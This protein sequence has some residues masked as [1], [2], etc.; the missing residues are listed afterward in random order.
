MIYG[1]SEG[2]LG[3]QALSM[4]PRVPISFKSQALIGRRPYPLRS[5]LAFSIRNQIKHCTLENVCYIGEYRRWEDT[6]VRIKEGIKRFGSFWSPLL[7]D[8]EMHGMLSI[9]D[10]GKI[11]LEANGPLMI[12]SNN[13]RRI[14]GRVEKHGDVTLDGCYETRT[15]HD[16]KGGISKKSFHVGTVLSGFAYEDGEIPLFNDLSFS[17]EGLDEWVGLNGMRVDLERN[18]RAATIV[19]QQP[20]DVLLALENGMQLLITFRS[21]FPWGFPKTSDQS[22][23]PRAPFKSEAT[24]CQKT[25]LKLISQDAR[26]LQ[27]FTTV[28]Q[29][30]TTLLCFATDQIVSVDKMWATSKTLRRDIGKGQT[31]KVP[32]GIYFRSRPFSKEEP[33]ITRSDFLFGFNE[34]SNNAE[35]IIKK[36]I[37][38]YDQISP[39]FN[40]YFSAQMASQQYLED[41]FLSLVQGLETYHRRTS[42]DT[43]MDVVEFVELS[44]NLINQCPEERRDW[45]RGKMEHANELNLRRRIKKLIEPFK[46]I[47]GNAQRREKLVARI[48]DSRNYL[49]HYNECLES[50]AVVGADLAP[51]CKKMEALFQLHFLQLI[52]FSEGELHS[53]VDRCRP[54]AW[55]LRQM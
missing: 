22:I 20:E 16:F 13:F 41:R 28:A 29:K 36:W 17:V 5:A 19:Y 43:Y 38:A 54:L 53:I 10:G 1:Y 34:V 24:I 42:D 45:L 50:R 46:V 12:P 47:I 9:S 33:M 51:L 15:E 48:V 7:P 14:I 37:K 49:T 21:S 55:K 40:L 11:E 52:G 6:V 4:E 35:A 8:Q 18:D 2:E 23:S 27:D 32:I 31:A 39:T 44:E 26:E 25:Y 3:N 30:I